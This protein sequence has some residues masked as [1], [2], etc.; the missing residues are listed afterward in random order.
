VKHL[1]ETQFNQYLDYE[2]DE[3]AQLQI[4]AHLEICAKCRA[5]F[6][7]LGMVFST[8]AELPDVPL[9]RDLTAS[10]MAN[11]PQTQQR[12]A[13]WRQPA[14]IMQSILTIVLLILSMPIFRI[15][16][17]RVV[18][19]FQELK[20][21]TAQIPSLPMLLDHLATLLSPA[22]Y[23]PFTVP[24]LPELPA[25]L[26]GPNVNIMLILLIMTGVLWMIGNV[27]LLRNGSGA[28]G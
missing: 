2:L 15:W 21:P 26:S 28:A 4:E 12:P 5:L 14:F 16:G 3:E 13:L 10:I 24:W 27:S 22:S 7:E 1:T 23:L 20:L 6:N 19:W 17:P 9:D 25:Q 8:L 11:L 18:V